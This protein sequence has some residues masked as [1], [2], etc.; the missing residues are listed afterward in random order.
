M[1][2]SPP[3]SGRFR[4]ATCR[5]WGDVPALKHA[6]RTAARRHFFARVG[7]RAIRERAPPLPFRSALCAEAPVSV[8]PS[9]C[10]DTSGLAEMA[11]PVV[12]AAG[13][14]ARH[15]GR[16]GRT[17]A[18]AAEASLALCPSF[19]RAAEQREAP[20]FFQDLTEGGSL[21]AREGVARFPWASEAL[22]SR[23]EPYATM[24]DLL[25][26]SRSVAAW[27]CIACSLMAVMVEDLNPAFLRIRAE[28]FAQHG[29][30]FS[31][32]PRRGKFGWRRRARW[33]GLRLK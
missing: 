19:Y 18:R 33:A 27:S 28:Y 4:P 24:L 16:R 15:A 20:E 25:P 22:Q 32:V 2:A 5:R 11:E 9:G 7:R 8:V 1:V 17:R 10:L 21:S 13:T 3:G 29:D 26:R 12:M 23:A 14:A 30:V 6:A 31:V